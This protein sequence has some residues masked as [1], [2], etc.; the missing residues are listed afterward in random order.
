M[1]IREK[2]GEKLVLKIKISYICYPSEK[3]QNIVL[4]G[5][6]GLKKYNIKTVR[7]KF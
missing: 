4:V 5:Q 6:N 2:Y 7:N 3:G 1:I